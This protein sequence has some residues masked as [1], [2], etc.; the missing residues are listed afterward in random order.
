MGQFI[1]LMVVLVG[2]IAALIGWYYEIKKIKKDIKKKMPTFD[3]IKDYLSKC[4]RYEED[5]YNS[6][7]FMSAADK[8]TYL[9]SEDW[10]ELKQKLKSLQGNKCCLC[11]SKNNLNVHHITYER[12]G[13][14]ELS[15]LRLLCRKCHIR[16]HEHY[17]YSRKT[18]YLPLKI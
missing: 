8:K 11:K 15:D 18:E 7:M 5:K 17:G 16:Q 3:E 2:T 6:N 13:N 14:E 9:Q 1:L 12:L 10:H 4:K